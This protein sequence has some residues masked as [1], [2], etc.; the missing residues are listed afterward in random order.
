MRPSLGW[1]QVGG[2]VGCDV[3]SWGGQCNSG[4]WLRIE[5]RAI[6]GSWPSLEG[7]KSLTREDKGG[8][9]LMGTAG[10]L[11]EHDLTS[12]GCLEA[13]TCISTSVARKVKIS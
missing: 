11:S 10:V 9:G 7:I 3:H 4:A 2:E 12:G 8:G 6:L 1:A 5:V 13:P